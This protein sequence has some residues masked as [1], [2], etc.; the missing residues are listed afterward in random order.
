M[1][2]SNPVILYLLLSAMAFAPVLLV[3]LLRKLPRRTLDV[4]E[5][6]LG[7]P[8]L[9]NDDASINEPPVGKPLIYL[10]RSLEESRL[11]EL[12]LGLRF[13]PL[14]KTAPILKRYLHS[15]DAELQ[16]YAQSIMQEGQERLQSRF[17]ITHPLATADSPTNTASFIGA[18][19][20]LLDSPL[21]PDSEYPAIINKVLVP[22]ERVL[23]SSTEHPRLVFET[24]R[25]CVRTDRLEDA[26]RM[27]SR[28]PKESP[29][30]ERLRKLLDH[31]Q[32][33]LAPQPPLAFRYDIN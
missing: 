20:R 13:L 31:R 9:L 10:T 23:A 5:I 18:G 27:L 11:R 17:A 24:G 22:A 16:L 3:L 1:S 4:G 30:H 25:F 33:I 15:G 8:M 21:T 12:M 32:N 2:P 26:S 28:L 7:N 14:E 6:L 19:L 29:L